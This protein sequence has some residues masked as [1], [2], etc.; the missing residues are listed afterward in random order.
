MEDRVFCRTSL[1]M[2]RWA[3]RFG[4]VVE[5]MGMRKLPVSPAR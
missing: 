5:S 2:M 4:E 1:S 3:A